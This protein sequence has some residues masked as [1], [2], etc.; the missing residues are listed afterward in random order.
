MIAAQEQNLRRDITKT[1]RTI[2]AQG[3]NQGTSGNISARIEG[4]FLITPS[5]VDYEVC[6]PA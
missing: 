4:G 6:A 3:I 1:A 2:N 5:N